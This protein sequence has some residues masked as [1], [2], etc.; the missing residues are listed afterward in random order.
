MAAFNIDSKSIFNRYYEKV[1]KEA[2]EKDKTTENDPEDEPNTS[3]QEG[4][5]TENQTNQDG[6]DVYSNYKAADD[7]EK[8][9]QQQQMDQTAKDLGLQ[10]YNMDTS[11]VG[12]NIPQT[13]DI[14]T[15]TVGQGTMNQSP[16][17]ETQPSTTSEPQ[18]TPPTESEKALF[19][20][21]HASDYTPGVG[22]KRLAELRN[23][24][25][26]VGNETDIGK[27]AN[28][29]YA[30]QYGDTD[31]GQAYAQRAQKQ[32]LDIG[33]PGQPT[34]G[35]STAAAQPQQSAQAPAPTTTQA[36]PGVTVPSWRNM[37]G[38][39]QGQGPTQLNALKQAAQQ[40][41]IT[42]NDDQLAKF[43]QAMGIS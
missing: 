17:S 18:N 32:G 28:V 2:E 22:D 42:M 43:A 3:E 12:S 38:V 24:V 27:I 10:N 5:G 33:R 41:G 6:S 30:Q 25:K 39:N 8:A 7:S 23:A 16:N 14:A 4:G 21:L 9:E 31:Q 26:T 40:A 11:T 37:S 1:I 20:K 13:T 35:T 29:A 36:A 34:G 15:G 19:K